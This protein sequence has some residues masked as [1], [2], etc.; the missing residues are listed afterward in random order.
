[1]DSTIALVV[2]KTCDKY[3]EGR[4]GMVNPQGWDFSEKYDDELLDACT[5]YTYEVLKEL[6][7]GWRDES[8]A[9]DNGFPGALA[10]AIRL[11]YLWD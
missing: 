1:M 7:E 3:I 2:A 6:A 10:E 11:G 8:G 5:G 9:A 4:H